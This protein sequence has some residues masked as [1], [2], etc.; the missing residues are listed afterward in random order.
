MPNENLSIALWMPVLNEIKGLQV[1]LPQIDR[2]LFSEV[3]AIDGGSTDGTIEFCE[4]AG[5]TVLRQPNRGMPDAMDFAY[6][7]TSADIIIVFTPDGNSLP[8]VLP[9]LCAKMRDGYDLV[10]VSRYLAGAE[11]H[12]DGF[13]TGLGNQI[14]TAMVS[15]IF[16]VRYTDVL[17]AYRGYKRS[18]IEK[19]SLANH[20]KEHWLRRKFFY[21]NGWELGSAIRAARLGLRIAEI[22]GNEPPRI[23]GKSKLSIFKNGFGSLFQILFDLIYFKTSS[24]TS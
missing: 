10:I 22:P 19:M 15:R 8:D 16:G 21:M 4:K 20:T 7:K 14:F 9:T 3:I 17:V 5:V 1:I 6:S 24:K 23:G 11:S 18:A 13:V 2:M 12:D